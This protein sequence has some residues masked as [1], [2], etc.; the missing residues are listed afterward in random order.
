MNLKP[1]HSISAVII[2][3][4]GGQEILNCIDALFNQSFALEQILVVDNASTD[5]SPGQITK[6]Y[7][8]VDIIRL[9]EN[10]GPAVARN[11]GLKKVDSKQVLFLD[12]D[13]Y[14]SPDCIRILHDSYRTYAPAMV[15]PRIVFYDTP[16]IVQCDG[17]EL[18]YIC[19][20]RLLNAYKPLAEL[21]SSPH[22]VGA[23]ISACILVNKEI[24]LACGGFDES[25]FFYH[26]DLELSL[27]LRS[28]GHLIFC[29][30]GATAY[31]D[32]GK[33]T[34]GLSYRYGI[35]LYPKKRAYY[36]ILHRLLTLLIHYRKRTFIVISPVLLLYETALFV[37]AVKRGWIKSWYH[38]IKWIFLNKQMI[39]AK[40]KQVQTRRAAHD[41]DI[42]SGGDLP[43]TAGFIEKRPEQ[44]IVK[45]LSYILNKYW[46]L[47]QKFAG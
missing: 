23:C 7:P 13:V 33:G 39:I 15:C 18:H 34:T 16:K 14:V 31:H 10:Y 44:I 5:N 4:N 22:E 42:L 1:V 46:Q 9:D 43:F 28:S 36:T 3:H 21:P 8:E 27:K 47:I 26:E 29:D 45:L 20:M 12:D 6:K 40:R 30:P 24:V 35:T 19:M 11:V 38:A 2:N 17:A 41:R 25:Y 37:M 32:P